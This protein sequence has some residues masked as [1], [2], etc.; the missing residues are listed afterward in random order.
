MEKANPARSGNDEVIPMLTRARI[1]AEARRARKARAQDGKII[2]KLTE[3]LAVWR[4]AR[5]ASADADVDE[6]KAQ[7]AQWL[8]QLRRSRRAELAALR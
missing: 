3:Q 8:R 1:Q 7:V 2:R 6:V 5:E 4:D